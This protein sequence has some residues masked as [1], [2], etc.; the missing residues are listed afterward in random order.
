MLHLTL[1]RNFGKKHQVSHA[2]TPCIQVIF[3]SQRVDPILA[4]QSKVLI[5]AYVSIY[6]VQLQSACLFS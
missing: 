3:A 6:F 2:F 1:Q 4:S 5:F